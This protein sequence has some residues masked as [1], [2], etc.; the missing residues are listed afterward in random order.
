M[1]IPKN[2][3]KMC[4][5]AE[6]IHPLCQCRIGYDMFARYKRRLVWIPFLH[7]LFDMVSIEPK[8]FMTHQMSE[9]ILQIFSLDAFCRDGLGAPK[10]YPN[11]FETKEELVLAFVMASKWKK[12]WD[13]KK[14]VNNENR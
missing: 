1:D 10:D 3:I 4:Y 13:G 9:P 8:G 11:K 5:Y 2:Y 14:W 6:E 7:Q 12:V